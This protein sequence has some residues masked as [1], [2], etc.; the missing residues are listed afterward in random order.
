[1]IS[2]GNEVADTVGI[3]SV[4]R[5]MLRPYLPSIQSPEIHHNDVMSVSTPVRHTTRHASRNEVSRATQTAYGIHNAGPIKAKISAVAFTE[6]TSCTT[7]ANN[8]GYFQPRCRKARITNAVSHGSA[9]QGPSSTLRRDEYSNAYGVNAN[10]SIA[11]GTPSPRI[12]NVRSRYRIPIPA[13]YN[14]VPSQMRCAT[15]AGIWST[16]SVNQ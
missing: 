4:N 2:Y 6:L 13:A 8:A 1:M 11:T 3:D 14:N 5:K 15:Q 9:D 12:P 10:A 7:S 16:C